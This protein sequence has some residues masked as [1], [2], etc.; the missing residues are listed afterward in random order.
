[1]LLELLLP[2]GNFIEFI[3]PF[4]V[5]LLQWLPVLCPILIVCS[6]Q[7]IPQIDQPWLYWLIVG[8]LTLLWFFRI[9]ILKVDYTHEAV[10]LS[11]LYQILRP[12]FFTCLN[13]LIIIQIRYEYFLIVSM[14][15]TIV[16]FTICVLTFNNLSEEIE[17]SLLAARMFYI[18]VLMVRF[19]ELGFGT[20]KPIFLCL[21][22]EI[23]IFVVLE[24][25]LRTLFEKKYYQ[26][27]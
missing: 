26:L 22:A 17:Y 24:K 12:S 1:V 7:I 10:F 6:C 9:I 19:L 18:I 2:K 21:L 5:P 25:F 3:K 20:V 13:I 14:L 8:F 15:F 16:D 23:L 4:R 11:K 27:F